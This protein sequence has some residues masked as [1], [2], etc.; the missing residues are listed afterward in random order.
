MSYR[1]QYGLAPDARYI[2]R[3]QSV[4]VVDPRTSLVTRILDGLR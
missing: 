4:Y 1:D 3:D 2:Y